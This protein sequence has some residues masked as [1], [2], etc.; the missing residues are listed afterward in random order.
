MKHFC[1][2]PLLVILVFVAGTRSFG[3]TALNNFVT[4]LLRIEAGKAAAADAYHFENP[5]R[6]WI[7]LR[8]L[9]GTGTSDGIALTIDASAENGSHGHII[10]Q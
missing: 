1:P 5:R 6:G 4:Q 3:D 8:A 7:F 10:H 9:T 2:V